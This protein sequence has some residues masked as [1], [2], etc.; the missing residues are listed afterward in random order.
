MPD[1]VVGRS[2]LKIKKLSLTLS[3]VLSLVLV[4]VVLSGCDCFC[5]SD[6]T[7]RQPTGNVED[8]WNQFTWD[9]LTSAEQS[10]WIILGWDVDSWEGVTPAPASEVKLWNQLSE[11]ERGAATELGYSQQSWDFS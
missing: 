9:E 2:M 10:L 7:V 4:L 1:L 6:S 8:F 5:L 11:A 3:T